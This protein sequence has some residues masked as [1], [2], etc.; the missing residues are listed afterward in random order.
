MNEEELKA[1]IEGAFADVASKIDTMMASV[2]EKIS[3]MASRVET[4]E[5]TKASDSENKPTDEKDKKDDDDSEKK[6]KENE[7]KES[8]SA[9]KL[10]AQNKAKLEAGNNNPRA[11]N[12]VVNTAQGDVDNE[13]QAKI[14]KAKANFGKS[15]K[16]H[17]A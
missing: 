17:T 3:A 1:M 6:K 11:N 15:Y 16:R 12:I 9:A 5:K 2:D 8:A 4:L 14:E 10:E 13:K 7:E